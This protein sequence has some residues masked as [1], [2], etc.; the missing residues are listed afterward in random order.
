M[1]VPKEKTS[2]SVTSSTSLVSVPT[3]SEINQL[4]YLLKIKGK[5]VILSHMQGFSNTYIPVNCLPDFPKPLTDIFDLKKCDEV[6]DNYIITS[7]QAKAVESKTK[8]QVSS[9]IWFQQR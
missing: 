2:T 6:Y 3:I 1:K 9:R 4:F 7:D 5:P 8:G